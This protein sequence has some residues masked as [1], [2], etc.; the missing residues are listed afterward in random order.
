MTMNDP[1]TNDFSVND[2]EQVILTKVGSVEEKIRTHV[3]FV[4]DDD[5]RSV[6]VKAT[7]TCRPG[8]GVMQL[9][10]KGGGSCHGR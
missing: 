7:S 5:F 2:P 8:D 3:S 1:T 6:D 4:C 10:W 9:M